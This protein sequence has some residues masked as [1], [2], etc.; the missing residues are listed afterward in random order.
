MDFVLAVG[1]DLPAQ[2]AQDAPEL[3]QHCRNGIEQQ[4]VDRTRI[5]LDSRVQLVR[6]REDQVDTARADT[7]HAG[8]QAIAPWYAKSSVSSTLP[9]AVSLFD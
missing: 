5:A 4:A 8:R 3:D 2:P 7:R 6:E 9:L 1:D